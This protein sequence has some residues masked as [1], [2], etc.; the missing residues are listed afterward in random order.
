MTEDPGSAATV[1]RI[2]FDRVVQDCARGQKL[3]AD[4]ASMLSAKLEPQLIMT[5]IGERT[6]QFLP[7]FPA[8]PFGSKRKAAMAVY[9]PP[10]KYQHGHIYDSRHFMVADNGGVEGGVEG[11]VASRIRGWGRLGYLPDAEE[12]QDEIG[13]MMADALNA[14]YANTAKTD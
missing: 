9:K 4:I 2:D 6:G 12:L 14:L 11:A 7:V 3:V 5:L 13:R 10:F 8:P 1:S